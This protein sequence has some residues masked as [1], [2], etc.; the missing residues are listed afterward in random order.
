MLKYY[1]DEPLLQSVHEHFQNMG[2]PIEVFVNM[3]N[4]RFLTSV[5]ETAAFNSKI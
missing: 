3:L 4:L 2:G 1:L 5:H